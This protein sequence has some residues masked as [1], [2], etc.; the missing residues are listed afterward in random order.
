LT[1][2][3][4]ELVHWLTLHGLITALAVLLYVV[5]SRRTHQ[6]RHPSAAISW[7]LFIVLVPY[8]A[9]P[10]FL[11][12]GTRK[13]RRP[14]R[15][16]DGHW[17]G[18][19]EPLRDGW[20]GRVLRAVGQPAP[21]P[22]R[23]VH[24]HADGRAAL[25]ALREV[26]DGATQSL[27]VCTFILADDD[28]GRDAL[29]RLCDRARAGVRVRLMLDGMGSLMAGRP[30]LKPLQDCGGE[31]TLFVPPFRSPVKGRTNLRNHRKLVIADAAGDAR[32]WCGGRNLAAEYFEGDAG[33]AAWQDLTF[34][35]RGP[36][37]AQAR[38]L[39]ERDWVFAKGLS[40]ETG[41]GHDV[42]AGWPASMGL[43]RQ[44]M[45]AGARGKVQG[46]DTAF[47]FPTI[48]FDADAQ[49]VASGPDQAD[50][51]LVA[52]LLTA[53]YNAGRRILIA[54][55]YFVPEPELLL[56]LSL[57]ARR[58]VVVDLLIPARSNH[59]M[60]DIARN[61]ALRSLAEAGGRVWATPEMMHGKLVVVDET[62]VLAGSANLDS[63]SLFLNYELMMA[64]HGAT[65]C[66]TFTAWF[67]AERARAAAFE[68]APPG[69]L[70]D[71]GEGMLLWTGFQL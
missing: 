41:P 52:L 25:E 51:T 66:A 14:N 38:D 2:A 12:F 62:L 9:L 39:F 63:R 27:D 26:I 21:V 4:F 6:R 68:P 5:R 42:G 31:Y 37:V 17:A 65:A 69:L 35:L 40:A 15:V 11:I 20:A 7:M 24:L 67:D 64:L 19:P 13:R 48:A 18:V 58:G 8:I 71:L 22:A 33:H 57:A 55:P 43:P 3:D 56:A 23:A 30:K 59:R 16:D 54:T 49:L 44:S 1:P 36:V 46:V 60:S 50:D 28:V 61:R 34:D 53:F 10:A 47:P 45:G 32:L 29:A 70:R